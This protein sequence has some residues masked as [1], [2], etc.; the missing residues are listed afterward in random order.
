MAH[1]K[2]V[3]PI[4]GGGNFFTA[5]QDGDL[6]AVRWYL[7]HNVNVNKV[8]PRG[9]LTPLHIASSQGHVEIVKALLAANVTHINK[10]FC[11]ACSNSHV[12]IVQL[13]L[14][15]GA[16]PNIALHAHAPLTLAIDC[17]NIE[18][19][20]LLLQWR[21]PDDV[22]IDL[23]KMAP[24]VIACRYAYIK[25]VQLLL[26]AG[27]SV[28]TVDELGSSALTTASHLKHY[29]IVKL[30][31]ND[32]HIDVNHHQPDGCTALMYA[33]KNGKTKIVQELL[34]KGADPNHVDRFNNSALINACKRQKHKTEIVNMLL[35]AG[36]DPNHVDRFGNTALIVACIMACRGC[37]GRNIQ[38]VCDLLSKGADPNHIDNEGGTA[39]Y[40]SM[41]SSSDGNHKITNILLEAAPILS[42]QQSIYL[43]LFCACRNGRIGIVRRLMQVPDID[44]NACD[45]FGLTPL[46]IATIH[47][48]KS[49]V[50]ML[51]ADRRVEY[52]PTVSLTVLQLAHIMN[53]HSME[54]EANSMEDEI[55]QKIKQR[56]DEDR[57]AMALV[58][59]RTNSVRLDQG[60]LNIP[61]EIRDLV[62]LHL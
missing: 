59:E 48:A 40:Y 25:I 52:H 49:L 9:G 20:R 53:V 37:R 57:L 34:S 61:K 24:V 41:C 14:A 38:I 42:K 47:K 7:G 18:I 58:I 31:L 19:I 13:L 21:S 30:L 4:Y 60:E 39:L 50:Q 43:T 22:K 5:C 45:R 54:D 16:D 36:A 56:Q 11:S 27:A 26:D 3:L 33:S 44:L 15:A 32:P 2:I 17:N 35:N 28:N 51:M 8:N 10:A 55:R 62:H 46:M 12:E 1:H 29:D 6:Q 23:N